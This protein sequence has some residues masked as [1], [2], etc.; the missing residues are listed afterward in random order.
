MY[1]AYE[2]YLNKKNEGDR[3]ERE[4]KLLLESADDLANKVIK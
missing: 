4:V 2:D 3:D 1:D